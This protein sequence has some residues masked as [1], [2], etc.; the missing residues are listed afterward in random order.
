M[1][2]PVLK[3]MN[4]RTDMAFDLSI[5]KNLSGEYRIRSQTETRDGSLTVGIKAKAV[6]LKAATFA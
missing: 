2:T 3:R 1:R 6:K 5:M 4:H